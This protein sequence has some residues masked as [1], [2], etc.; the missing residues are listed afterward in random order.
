[1]KSK[2]IAVGASLAFIGQAYASDDVMTAS[3]LHQK[4]TD[5]VLASE[6]CPGVKMDIKKWDAEVRR[7]AGA[8]GPG[9]I[10]S[11]Q[12]S[13]QGSAWYG[14]KTEEFQSNQGK[15]CAEAL[16]QYGPTGTSS[17]G[18]LIKKK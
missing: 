3:L 8:R 11:F 10:K 4:Y 7:D 5:V 9:L 6:F 16:D 15:S 1:M 18:L 14:N 13:E 17:K 2:F 12:V